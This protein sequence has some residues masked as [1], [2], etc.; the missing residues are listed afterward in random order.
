LY[1]YDTGV[2]C[3]LL[4]I[5]NIN[6]LAHHPLRGQ[7]FENYIALEIIKSSF[8]A[9]KEPDLYFFRDSA[10]NEIDFL[11]ERGGYVVPIEVK[12]SSTFSN[13]FLRNINYYR[14]LPKANVRSPKILYAGTEQFM[15]EDVEIMPWTH[16]GSILT[17]PGVPYATN[18]RMSKS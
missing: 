18:S 12:A 3:F 2:L 16:A 15:V 5:R 8:N 4:S 13:D 11:Q 9:V 10:G 6:D 1:F 7:I 17:D 14:A